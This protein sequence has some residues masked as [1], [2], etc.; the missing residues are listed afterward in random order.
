MTA[1][2]VAMEASDLVHEVSEPAEDREREAAELTV[3]NA[4]ED[5]DDDDDAERPRSSVSRSP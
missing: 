4:P 5:D 3:R 1:A 2:S